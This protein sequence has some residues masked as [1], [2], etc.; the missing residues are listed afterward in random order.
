MKKLLLFLGCGILLAAT[1]CKKYPDSSTVVVVTPSY[2]TVTINGPIYYSIPVN[3]AA[4]SVS[5]S[6]YDSLLKESYPVA[7]DASTL[8]SSL[9]GLYVVSIKAT[10][11]YGYSSSA[12][13]YVAVTNVSASTNLAGT[14]KRTANSELVHVT[15]LANGLYETDDVGGVPAASAFDIPAVFVHIDDTTIQVPKQFIPDL[16]GELYCSKDPNSNG[17]TRESTFCS[18]TMKPADTSYSYI[19][20]GSGFGKAVRTFKKQ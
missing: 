2:P 12:N 17:D 1:S 4:P 16:G 19:V 18:L 13:V 11:K 6:A 9:P 14:Y 20:F 8:N 5:A 10:N 7:M 15:K 3:A